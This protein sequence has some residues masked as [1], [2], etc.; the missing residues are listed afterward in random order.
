M[1][2]CCLPSFTSS[3]SSSPLVASSPAS[4]RRR[5][6]KVHRAA[7]ENEEQERELDEKT[8]EALRLPSKSQDDDPASLRKGNKRFGNVEGGKYGL[9]NRVDKALDATTDDLQFKIGAIVC[10][11]LP[12]LLLIFGPRPPSEY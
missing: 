6:R 9:G 1:R 8:R 12:V 2:T 7:R 3:S 5:L 11:T 4:R 10:V